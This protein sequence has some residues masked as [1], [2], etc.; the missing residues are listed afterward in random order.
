MATVDSR[1][2][3]SLDELFNET[4]VSG[5]VTPDG[6][7]ILVTRGG[8]EINAGYLASQ[9]IR[10]MWKQENFYKAGD[11]VSYA[12]I[13]W[14]ANNDNIGKPPYFN[15]SVW[16]RLSG[17]NLDDWVE[18]DSYFDGDDINS[19]WSFFW[20][21][22]S[23]VVSL[24]SVPGDFE[25]GR[26]GVQIVVPM[27]ST[28]HVAPWTENVV[29]TNDPLLVRVRTR[30]SAAA[31]NARVEAILLQ[32]DDTGVPDYFQPGLVMT[33]SA[34]GQQAISTAW[35]SY[36][37]HITPDQLKPRGRISV[38][39][40]SNAAGAVFLLDYI[41]VNPGIIGGEETGD[42]YE[43]EFSFS[44]SVTPWI[45]TH[46]Q[47]HRNLN[48]YTEDTLGNVLRGDVSYP[49]DNQVRVDFYYSQTGKMRVWN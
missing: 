38:R 45:A 6:V 35:Q 14:R 20:K 30:L 46:N 13:I 19:A 39:F 27:G 44:S 24:T 11:L 8:A 3:I 9:P 16:I 28:Q 17:D 49:N 21:A 12:G 40:S 22:G 43:Q 10:E 48:V 4:V 42:D 37:F 7:L 2:V 29:N 15:T 33:S 31:P 1:T 18:A 26:Q 23:P 47:G 41:R 36:D 34:E 25:S 5:Y 32:N